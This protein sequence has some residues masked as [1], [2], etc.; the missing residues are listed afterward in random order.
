MSGILTN[1]DLD[2]YM[3]KKAEDFQKSSVFGSKSQFYFV[4]KKIDCT[5]H[6]EVENKEKV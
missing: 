6:I 1:S 3:I 4:N 5:I 2:M